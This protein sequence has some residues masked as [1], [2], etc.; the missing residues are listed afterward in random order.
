[1]KKSSVVPEPAYDYAAD[2][3]REYGIAVP[4]DGVKMSRKEALDI[5]YKEV[6]EAKAQIARGEYFT[7]EEAWAILDSI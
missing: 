7:Q 4:D 5:L 1:M 6:A 3:E 2:L